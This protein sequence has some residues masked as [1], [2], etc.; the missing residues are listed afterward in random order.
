MDRAFYARDPE[1]VAR[2]LLG[3]HLA[4]GDRRGRI[5]ETEAY[6]GADDPAS[7][8]ATGRTARNAPMFGPPGNSYV[9]IS[10]GIHAMLNVV[11][12]TE[13]AP[14]AVLIR[15]AEP[16]EGVEALRAARGVDD[17]T[18]LCS[19]PGKLTEAFGIEKR[20]DDVD[21]TRGDPRIEA[22]EAGGEISRSPRIGV[23]SDAPLRFALDS[24]HVSR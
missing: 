15:A 7:H 13:G 6:R 16:L 11:T 22:G 20:H 12:G 24:P 17:D 3:A 19:G 9:Y 1:E 18:E 14:S 8:A 23:D 21:L 4:H 5:V 2:A 10:Y